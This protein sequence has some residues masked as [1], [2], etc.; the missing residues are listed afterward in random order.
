[1]FY[2]EIG[3]YLK[4]WNDAPKLIQIYALYLLLL[5]TSLIFCFL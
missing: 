5:A 4:F 3:I 2:L 1:M